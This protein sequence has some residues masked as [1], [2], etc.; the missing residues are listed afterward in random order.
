LPH[1][2]LLR[3]RDQA[4][5]SNPYLTPDGREFLKKLDPRK[6]STVKRMIFDN[7]EDNC[8]NASGKIAKLRAVVADPAATAGEKENAAR[9]A[10][11]LAA[12]AETSEVYDRW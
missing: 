7:F 1:E 6:S 12:K 11:K 10:E 2:F 4:L 8:A 9:L 5:A 3:A